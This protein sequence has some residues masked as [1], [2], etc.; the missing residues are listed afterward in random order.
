MKAL[1]KWAAN[2]NRDELDHLI[3][4]IVDEMRAERYYGNVCIESKNI[5]RI[6]DVLQ[7]NW[8]QLGYRSTESSV[9][10]WLE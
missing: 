9:Y 2:I 4:E 3:S 7:T 10:I 6:V 1:R 5:S 8:P